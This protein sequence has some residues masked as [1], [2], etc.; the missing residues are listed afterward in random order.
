MQKMPLIGC[1]FLFS[2]LKR[3]GFREPFINWIEILYTLASATFNANGPTSCSATIFIELL[4]AAI[5]IHHKIRQDPSSLQ[6][7][8]KFILW[9]L[10]IHHLCLH[11][12]ITVASMFSPHWMNLP[13][14]IMDRIS[15]VI[16]SLNQTIYSQTEP[17]LTWFNTLDSTITKFF[18]K[19]TNPRTK[20][21]RS[22]STPFQSL[23]SGQSASIY[24]NG[25]IQIH[26]EKNKTKHNVSYWTNIRIYKLSLPPPADNQPLWQ[27]GGISPNQKCPSCIIWIHLY[28]E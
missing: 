28:L 17:T 16:M 2:T 20:T 13:L 26:Q 18:W 1:K 25:L 23:L 22:G 11:V 8:F 9:H 15:V 4:A 14:F 27:L 3:F 7:R 21:K 24:A 12:P 10:R 19:N 6:E 5:C